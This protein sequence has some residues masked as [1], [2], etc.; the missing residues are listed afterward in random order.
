MPLVRRSG[1]RALVAGM[2]V[3]LC[4]TAGAAL[5]PFAHA[6][7]SNSASD[8]R[9]QADAL[10][11]K[12]FTALERVQSLDDDIASSE[13]LVEQLSTRAKQAHAAARAR[14]LIAYTSA[15]SQLS[16]LVDS[17]NTLD[18]A[19]RAKLIDRVNEHDQDVFENLQK[20]T[21]ALNKQERE[22]RAT[23]EAQA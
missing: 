16:T 3:V 9:A 13:R 7:T 21:R 12:Y 19:R 6:Q 20:A 23:R 18:S 10:S 17:D 8:L 15:G 14:A 11:S 22:L 2:L 4:T 1:S 5:A